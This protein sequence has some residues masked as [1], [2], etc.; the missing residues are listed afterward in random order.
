[1]PNEGEDT[2]K[3][4]LA[5]YDRH[6]RKLPWR[7]PPGRS[8][9]PY[10]VWLSEIMLQQTTVAAVAPYFAAF[11]ARWPSAES[12]AEAPIE[13][14]MRQWAG[15]GY[16]SR[17][18]NLH[19]CARAIVDMHGGRFPD[20][21]AALRALPGIG[22]Y[23]AA[24][25]AAIAFGRRAVVVDGNVERVVA[26]LFAI[27]TPLPSAKALIKEK[28]ATLTPDARPGD[29]A[30]AMMD[31]GAT[32]CTP[33]K[34]LCTL[35]PL[36]AGCA[37]RASGAPEHYPRRAAKPERP[38]RHGTV[39][40]IRREDGM[41]LLRR[42]PPNGLLG[43]MSEF[44]GTEWI[45]SPRPEEGSRGKP[46]SKDAGAGPDMIPWL[47]V[48]APSA[49]IRKLATTIT[50]V[51][52]HFRLELEIHMVDVPRDLLAPKS[53]RWVPESDLDREALPSVMRKVLKALR[54]IR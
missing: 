24:A 16:Y 41:V 12:L 2:A 36:T 30:Q 4:A 26:R 31:L 3:L 35:C 49:R 42:R 29:Y 22:S 23:T 25:I 6:R 9:D 20:T 19:A 21:E 34:P 39:F 13:E 54:S 48:A 44:P 7:A 27:E 15:L 18:R 51:F 52:T 28:A 10:R 40:F 46:V 32:I 33:R 5:W 17:A 43:G 14:I 11:V 47:R 38:V 37:A 1:V 8:A 50:H 53:C 45:S